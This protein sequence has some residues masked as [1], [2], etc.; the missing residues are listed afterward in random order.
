MRK[1]LWAAAALLFA[2]ASCTTP[3]A[4][5]D[6]TGTRSPSVSLVGEQAV[7]LSAGGL[8]RVSQTTITVEASTPGTLL[9]LWVA[10]TGGFNVPIPG[11]SSAEVVWTFDTT[12]VKAQNSPRRMSLYRA[13]APAGSFSTTITSNFGNL[14]WALVEYPADSI[15]QR[16]TA[17]YQTF[18]PGG[19]VPLAPTPGTATVGAFFCGCV[20]DPVPGNGFVVVSSTIVNDRNRSFGMMTEFQDGLDTTV[21]ASWSP[22]VHWLGIAVALIP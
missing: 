22:P 2:S 17:V 7:A 14:I 18:E 5:P 12:V 3:L 20:S 15:V 19:L 13:T 8:T 1:T 21:D 16:A 10:N 11:V 9:L 4:P 6:T